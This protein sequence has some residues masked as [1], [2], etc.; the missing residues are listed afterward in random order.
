MAK[1]IT[2]VKVVLTA[3]HTFYPDTVLTVPK[4]VADNLKWLGVIKPPESIPRGEGSFW[5]N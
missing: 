5:E 3:N 1:E 4:E 2:E